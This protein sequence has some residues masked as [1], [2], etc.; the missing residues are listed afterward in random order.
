[1]VDGKP[2]LKGVDILLLM[3]VKRHNLNQAAMTLSV[4]SRRV[5][6]C[7]FLPIATLSVATAAK[8][9]QCAYLLCLQSS[10]S[11]ILQFGLNLFIFN[12]VIYNN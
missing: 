1:M 7:G 3:T 6:T 2:T 4:S 9:I 11:E 5:W 10:G 12:M 8:V